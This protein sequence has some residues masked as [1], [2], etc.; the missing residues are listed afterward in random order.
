MFTSV[1][2]GPD[3]Q[4][5]LFDLYAASRR[6]ELAAWGWDEAQQAAFLRIQFT[7]QQRSYEWQYP[8]A[9][10]RLILVEGEKA[11]RIMV[12]RGQDRIQ[13]VD[14]ALLPQYRRRGIGLALLQ[15]LQQETAAVGKPLALS[16]LKTNDGARRLYERLGFRITGDH[17]P[18]I[19]MV[20]DGDAR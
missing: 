18:Y 7:A 20:W 16:V 12:W 13:L 8:D 2:V 9:D 1:P 10:H 4:A 19:A 14:V 17:D 6:D 5:F 15:D 3:D 11:G